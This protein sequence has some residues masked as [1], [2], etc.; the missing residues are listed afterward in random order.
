MGNVKDDS[1]M[2]GNQSGQYQTCPPGGAT[3]TA[4]ILQSVVRAIHKL[5]DLLA[6]GGKEIDQAVDRNLPANASVEVDKAV[7]KNG[8]D[9]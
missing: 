5:I 8:E 1:S 9:M 3:R 7:V 2:A 6:N 4:A